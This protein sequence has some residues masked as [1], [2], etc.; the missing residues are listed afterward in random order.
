MG[1]FYFGSNGTAG[2]RTGI[3]RAA[4]TLDTVAGKVQALG[5]GTEHAM[6]G[7]PC[8]QK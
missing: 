5:D 4:F 6:P 2:K 3:C 8:R 7:T 1:F